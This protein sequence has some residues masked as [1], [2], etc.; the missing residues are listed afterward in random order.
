MS[1]RRP[2]PQ[3]A[4]RAGPDRAPT[5]RGR[6]PGRPCCAAPGAA[7]LSAFVALRQQVPPARPGLTAARREAGG[8]GGL[9]AG[10]RG[11]PRSAAGMRRA[12]GG[13]AAAGEGR[14][15]LPPLL[16]AAAAGRAAPPH[17]MRL[18]AGCRWVAGGGAGV[19]GAPGGARRGARRPAAMAA[20]AVPWPAA[21]APLRAPAPA[22]PIAGA[23]PARLSTRGRGAGPAPGAS[24]RSP[25]GGRSGGG[26]R[27]AEEPPPLGA[28]R[29]GRRQPGPSVPPPRGAG[30]PAPAAPCPGRP[31]GRPLG[32]P[33]PCGKFSSTSSLPTRAGA[34]VWHRSAGPTALRCSR[35]WS[36]RGLG[37][38]AVPGDTH[39]HRYRESEKEFRSYFRY[40]AYPALPLLLTFGFWREFLI[41]Q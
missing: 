4:A 5:A 16:P 30:R 41:I 18:P 9:A 20:G 19:P 8:P 22:P 40:S 35:C 13:G 38:T 28:S 17:G 21:A 11:A 27:G 29:G 1:L 6:A 34:A 39:T 24:P 23:E 37:A 36:R 2:S 26:G 15:T 10:P 32:G 31:R 7:P 33:R 25:G 3:A 12:A 14:A